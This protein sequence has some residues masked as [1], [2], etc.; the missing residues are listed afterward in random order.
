[1]LNRE[2]NKISSQRK[3]QKKTRKK[4]FMIYARIVHIYLSTLLFALMIL[5]CVTG[6]LLNHLEWLSDSSRD[7]E[8]ELKLPEQLRE[9]ILTADED[10]FVN[11]PIKA[12]QNL[13][14]KEHN[15]KKP[16]EITLDKEMGEIVLDYK[17]P[18]GYAA[19]IINTDDASLFI[20]YRKGSFWSVMNDLH[21]GR[22]SG[23]AWSWVIDLS[24]ILIILF[25]LTGMIILFQNKKHRMRA[26]LFALLGL[27]TPLIIYLSLVPRLSGV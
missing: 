1:M 3:K 27:L 7:G 4:G 11:P 6:L 9:T 24:A 12:I 13:L 18:A 8:V 25:S 20:E 10:L 22:N 5:F 16:S 2:Q 17:L 26:L 19:A 21:K 14:T 23:A 15:L